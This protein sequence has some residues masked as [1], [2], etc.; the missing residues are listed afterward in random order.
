MPQFSSN[1][2][3]GVRW[4]SRC[5]QQPCR[6]LRASRSNVYSRLEQAIKIFESQR[7]GLMQTKEKL[8]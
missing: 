8:N 4:L 6:H 5:L 2:E 7:H 1:V 3:P